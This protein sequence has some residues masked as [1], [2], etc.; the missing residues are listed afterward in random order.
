[1]K[2]TDKCEC[3]HDLTEEDLFKHWTQQGKKHECKMAVK[4]P[5]CEKETILE[6]GVKYEVWI[7]VKRTNS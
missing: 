7:R 3:Q 6:E 2:W 5:V 4:C 1:M